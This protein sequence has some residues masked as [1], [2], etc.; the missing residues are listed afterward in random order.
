MN[1]VGGDELLFAPIAEIARR[2]RSGAL[3]PVEVT[4]RTLARIAALNPT[5]NAF[6]TVTADLAVAAARQAEAELRAGADRGLL[7]GIPVALKDLVDTAGVRTTCGSRILASNVPERDAPIVQK[8]R[9]AGAVLVGKTNMLEFAYGIVHPDYGPAWNPYDPSRTAGGSSGGS[10]AAV[11]AGLCFAAVGTDTGGSIRIP[12]SYCGVAGF[13]PTYGLASVEGIFPLSQ[14]L[15]HVGPI[16]RTAADAALLLAALLGNDPVVLQPANLHGLRLGILAA[17]RTGAEMEPAVIAAFDDAC[18]ALEKAG[19]LLEDVAIPD[20]ALADDLLGSI[21]AP[22]ASVIHGDW[23]KAR[24]DEYAPLTRLQIEEGF[25]IPAVEYV[26]A[27][28]ERIRLT[29][30]FLAAFE[31]VD[32]ILSPTSP[33][34][35]PVEDPPS[36]SEAGA[37][38]ARRTGPYNLTGLPALTVNCGYGPT[39]LPIGLQIAT[40]LGSDA[41]CLAIGAAYEALR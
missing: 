17:H 5:L 1:H 16:A 25:D 15:D 21:I 32:A 24:P 3:S 35:A 7:H 9:D 26:G 13:K 20:L 19:A 6:I 14:S 33:W 29:E 40:S 28:L 30:Q 36:G 8:L 11:A 39:G 22:E 18:A 2:Y 27:Q 23:I 12:A 4:E 10:A 41:L 37:A 38:E 31:R 34:V